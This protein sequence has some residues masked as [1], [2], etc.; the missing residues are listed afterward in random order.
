M[1]GF[2]VYTTEV[3]DKGIDLVVRKD[4][5]TYYDVQVKSARGL[6]TYTFFPK[7]VFQLRE[8]LLV[9]YVMLLDREPPGL[10]L[11]R[12]S[13]WSTPSAL[14]VSRD[15]GEGY[16]SPPEWGIN[17]SQRNRGLLEPYGF[18]RVLDTL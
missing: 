10:Y 16:K 2:D 3:D 13:E 5:S 18:E 8:N 1:F 6:N 12:A 9:A 15:Y 7:R 14:L 11:I 17:L 4:E